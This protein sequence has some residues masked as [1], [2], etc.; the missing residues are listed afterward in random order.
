MIKMMFLRMSVLILILTSPSCKVKTYD[1]EDKDRPDPNFH[2]YILMGQSNM[3]GRGILTEEFERMADVNVVMLNKD[4]QWVPAKHPLHFDKPKMVA[5]G[6]GLSFGITMARKSPNVKI[7]LVPCAVGGSSIEVW[8]PGA[9]YESTKSHPYDDALARIKKAMRAGIVKGVLWHQGES[10]SSAEGAEKYLTQ[11][12]K[13]IENLRAEVHNKN[14]PFV[15]GELGRYREKYKYVNDELHKLPASV[16]YT[17]I[18]SSEGLTHKGDG[19]HL[20]ALS[21]K[22]LGERL[23]EKMLEIEKRN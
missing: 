19:T 3:S 17:A 22:I 20:D 23:A 9:Y 6:P 5:V 18:A 8:Q 15:A 12:K 10:N 11:L 16:R 14:L 4:Q 7:G 2:I 1:S 13:L 21:A